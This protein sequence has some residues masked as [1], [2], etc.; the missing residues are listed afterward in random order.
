MIGVHSTYCGNHFMMYV[1]QIV[2]LYTLNLHSAVY[3]LYLNTTERKIKR[4]LCMVWI[5]TSFFAIA[6][7]PLAGP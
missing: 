1:S 2:M 6:T 7:W 3:Q 5:L 4:W